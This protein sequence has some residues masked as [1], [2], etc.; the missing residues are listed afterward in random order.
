MEKQSEV[1]E[2]LIAGDAETSTNDD[3]AS[4]GRIPGKTNARLKLLPACRVSAERRF[5]AYQVIDAGQ[6]IRGNRIRDACVFDFKE[7][8]DG[9]IGGPRRDQQ[10]SMHKT[11]GASNGVGFTTRIGSFRPL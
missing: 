2:N 8:R 5:V 10:L 4:S 6:A 3:F 7:R 9:A 1:L 11:L